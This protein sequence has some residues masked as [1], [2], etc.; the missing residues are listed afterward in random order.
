MKIKYLIVILFYFCLLA[1]G[2]RV[3][4]GNNSVQDVKIDHPSNRIPGGYGIYEKLSGDLNADGVQDSI[5]VVKAKDST[6]VVENRYGQLVDRNRRGLLIFLNKKDQWEP[7]VQNMDCFASENE[8]GGNY[9]APQ[10][11]FAIEA[12]QLKVNYEHGR[13]GRWTYTFEFNIADFDLVY[14]E[15]YASNPGTTH[16]IAITK[17]DFTSKEKIVEEIDWEQTDEDA[18][19]PVYRKTVTPLKEAGFIKLSEIDDFEG[20]RL[21]RI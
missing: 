9:Y 5:I 11:S 17:I 20:L 18:N 13:Y 14:Y 2:Q 8:E 6:K 4:N 3:Y 1:C 19:D 10:L 21:S 7:I 12:N 15:H 16:D